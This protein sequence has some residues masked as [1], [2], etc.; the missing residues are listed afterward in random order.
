MTAPACRRRCAAE[1]FRPF[2]GSG[3]ARRHRP[4]AGDRPRSDG[5]AWR[6]HRAGRRRRDRHHVPAHPAAGRTGAP[7][8]FRPNGARVA[9]AASADVRGSDTEMARS[10]AVWTRRSTCGSPTSGCVRR[11]ICWR[12]CRSMRRRAWWISAAAPATSPRSCDSASRRRRSS[13]WT[14]R[15]QCW[16]RRAPRCRTAGFEQADFFQWQP[17]EPLDLIYSNAALQ[18]VDR[19]STLFPRLLSFLAPGGVL[20]VQMPAMHDTPLRR[21]RTSWP[22]SNPGRSI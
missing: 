4:R 22:P 18:W 10:A 13:A 17:T 6:R 16:R 12:R 8:G 21:S 19:H 11:W 15:P 5:G 20:A 14:G 3:A 2:A 1:L 7:S 9:P